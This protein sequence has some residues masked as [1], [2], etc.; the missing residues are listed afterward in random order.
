MGVIEE[1]A[2][3]VGDVDE[4][5][6][7]R[8][9]AAIAAQGLHKSYR[10][11]VA[12]SSVDLAVPSGTV[13]GLLGP[14]GAGK[15]TLIRMLST[16]LPPDAG[17]FSITGVPHTDPTRIRQCIGVLPESPGYPRGQTCAEWLTYHARLYGAGRSTARDTAERLLEEV[18]LTERAGSL[19][20]GLSRGM[21]Q[22]LGIARS[23]VNSPMVVFLDEPTLGLD[24]H[25]QRQVL[26]LVGRIA[27]DHGVTVV[28]S[29]HVLGEVEQACDL[30]LILNRGRIVAQGTVAEVVR[31]AAAPRQ[32][33]VRVPP[34][35]R[36][37]AIEA[38][39]AQRL[40]STEP[41]EEHARDEVALQL[42][43]D[44]PPEQSAAAALRCLL[45]A[46]VPVLGFSLE[47]GRLSDAFLSVTRGG[48]DD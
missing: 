23:L 39:A 30:V 35:V 15:T 41:L 9:E 36:A 47:G 38:L 2:G 3:L 25:G 14:N 12:V 28:L 4:V 16:I 5:D 48:S 13:L 6:G 1:S 19:I 18:G 43:A 26:D 34:D 45:D 17:A 27:R 11:R 46:G 32:G 40:A 8:A 21:R 10:G 20:S 7:A 42:P 24:P 33:V 29:T 22:R 44:V 31:R 37:R